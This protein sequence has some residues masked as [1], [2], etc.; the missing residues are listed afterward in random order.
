MDSSAQIHTRR[1]LDGVFTAATETNPGHAGRPPKLWIQDAVKEGIC[2]Y[3][4]Q[5]VTTKNTTRIKKVIM[6]FTYHAQS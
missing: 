4:S 6:E 3:C 1:M 2:N 5:I